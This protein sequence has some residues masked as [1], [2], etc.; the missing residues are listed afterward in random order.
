MAK[1]HEL[2]C[3]EP[4]FT[5]VHEERKLFE[6]RRNDRDFEV[7]DILELVS[8]KTSRR[9][10]VEVLYVLPDR[11]KPMGFVLILCA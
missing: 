7:G 6:L 4:Y 3:E 8:N 5:D 9:L 10:R 11:Q 2:K 1:L